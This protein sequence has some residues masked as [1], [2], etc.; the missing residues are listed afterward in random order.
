MT[1]HELHDD[2]CAI[3]REHA[4]AAPEPRSLAPDTRFSEDLGLDSFSLV[5]IAFAVRERFGVAAD[6]DLAKIR[7]LRGLAQYVIDAEGDDRSAA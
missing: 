7:T 1:D 3:V 6:P 5:C 4:P 2:L